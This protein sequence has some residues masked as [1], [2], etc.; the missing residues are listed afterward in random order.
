MII[1]NIHYNNYFWIMFF[2]FLLYD[3][4]LSSGFGF[5][6][7]I[8]IYKG[9]SSNF[10]LHIY[11]IYALSLV[12]ALS[13]RIG[14]ETLLLPVNDV[15][16]FCRW[17]RRIK[18]MNHQMMGFISMVYFLKGHD[19]IVKGIKKLYKTRKDILNITKE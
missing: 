19:G 2:T 16:C 8:K 6:T 5:W 7:N 4:K 9:F 18:S 10:T 3:L 12:G 15:L 14:L 17:C 11:H 1:V 13:F